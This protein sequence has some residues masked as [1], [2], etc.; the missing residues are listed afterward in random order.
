MFSA[1][2]SA[3]FSLNLEEKVRRCLV[4]WSIDVVRN[5]ALCAKS[6]QSLLAI[7]RPDPLFS[8]KVCPFFYCTAPGASVSIEGRISSINGS[9]VSS[10]SSLLTAMLNFEV[11]DLAI[12]FT[13]DAWFVL[14]L[15]S[16]GNSFSD[17]FSL[18]I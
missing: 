11:L 7:L 15:V 6:W 16:E 1:V 18:K 2:A 4:T 10:V 13:V 9:T 5:L 3:E 17:T 8:D 12:F 14:N